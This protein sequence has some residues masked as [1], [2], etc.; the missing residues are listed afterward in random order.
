MVLVKESAKGGIGTA[1]V[2]SFAL[3]E[4]DAFA[5]LQ[6]TQVI[7]AASETILADFIVRIDSKADACFEYYLPACEK[8]HEGDTCESEDSDLKRTVRRLY[9]HL[10]SLYL[11]PSSEPSSDLSSEPPSIL[12]ICYP[13]QDHRRLA[14]RFHD[15]EY[16]DISRRVRID[17]RRWRVNGGSMSD[18]GSYPQV[19]FDTAEDPVRTL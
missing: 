5:G 16:H 11:H 1:S 2:D 8:S 4:E 13:G 9:A 15:A 10:M 6:A 12:S 7:R 3:D 18:L 17:Q 14:D 19:T